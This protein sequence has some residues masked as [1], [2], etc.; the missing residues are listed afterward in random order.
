MELNTEEEFLHQ[1]L[2][3]IWANKKSHSE[4]WLFKNRRIIYSGFRLKR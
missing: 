1:I 2:N 4:K 3:M